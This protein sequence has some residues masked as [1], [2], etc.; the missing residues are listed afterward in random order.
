MCTESI[1]D[2]I[3]LGYTFVTIWFGIR[4]MTLVGKSRE[5]IAC[6]YY[7]VRFDVIDEFILNS[8]GSNVLSWWIIET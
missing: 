7:Q 6:E 4:P 1:P 3:F 8:H 2:I 5:H